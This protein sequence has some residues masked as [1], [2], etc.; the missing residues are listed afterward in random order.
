MPRSRTEAQPSLDVPTSRELLESL[1]T[2]E[3]SVG[4][5]Y[6]RM[7]RYSPRNIGFLALQGCPPSPVAT[8]KK[9]SELG[10][11]VKRGEKAY[12]ILRPIQVKVESDNAD[13]EA[14]MIRRFKVVRALF[15][16]AQVATGDGDLPP[17]EPPVWSETQ[18]L[19]TLDIKREPFNSFESNAQGYSYDRTVTVSPI[20]VFP[21]KTLMHEI[22]HVQHGHTTAEKHSDYLAHRGLREFEA[23]ASAHLVVNELGVLTPK[24]ASVSRGYV[25]NWL[26][27]EKPPEQLLR[28][29]LTVAT[30]I[31]DAGFKGKDQ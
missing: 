9:W 7:H 29:V 4:S 3:G 6:N 12:S 11:Q 15:H 20:A 26:S 17:Y 13:E 18:A 28:N 22:A 14:K 31:L 1:L 2:I 27:D 19:E 21:V 16:Y 30:Q 10:F 23:E 8:Y 25:Q 24:M 5:T